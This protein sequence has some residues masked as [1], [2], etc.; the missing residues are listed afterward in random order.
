M[1]NRGNGDSEAKKAEVEWNKD[2]R[3]VNW[4]GRNWPLYK[5][6]IVRYLTCYKVEDNG[7]RLDDICD[8]STEYRNTNGN[9]EEQRF[10]QQ[11]QLLAKLI[12]SSLSCT[13]A[14]Q[15]MRFDYG[16]DMWNYLAAR[17]EGRENKMTTLYTQRGVRQKLEGAYMSARCR[18]W[19]Q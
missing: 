2:G 11:D 3:P 14:Q 4:N 1:R 8:G 16:S 19:P 12:A 18:R 9:E 6:T 13:L 17:F 10:M 5:R 15:V 7:W